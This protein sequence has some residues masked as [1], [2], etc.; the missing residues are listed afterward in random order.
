MVDRAH[1]KELLTAPEDHISF[2]ES[3]DDHGFSYLFTGDVRNA[4]HN[5]IILGPLT[6]GLPEY[7]PFLIEELELALNTELG[8]VNTDCPSLINSS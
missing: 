4:Y 2:T 1:V 8:H 5:R 7:L 6:H 3:F